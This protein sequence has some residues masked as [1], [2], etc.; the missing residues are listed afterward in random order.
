MYSA[1]LNQKVHCRARLPIILE[2]VG[3]SWTMKNLL[4]ELLM[5]ILPETETGQITRIEFV[6]F[7]VLRCRPCLLQR[8]TEVAKLLPPTK[9]KGLPS[10]RAI[11]RERTQ[12]AETQPWAK[13]PGHRKHKPKCVCVSVSLSCFRTFQLVP[14][15]GLSLKE[16]R[17]AR[18][19]KT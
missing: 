14:R 2:S 15:A 17:L 1:P 13:H 5:A 8:R 9:Q 19:Q 7:L 12:R 6:P 4:P 3:F 10:A 18:A 11:L 16:S